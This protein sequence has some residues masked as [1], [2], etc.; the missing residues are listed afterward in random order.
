MDENLNRAVNF[1]SEMLTNTV[2]VVEKP[3][4]RTIVDIFNTSTDSNTRQMNIAIKNC[5]GAI[6]NEAQVFI[7]PDKI[8]SLDLGVL[9]GGCSIDSGIRHALVEIVAP[10]C[11]TC[12]FRL[13]SNGNFSRSIR[14][15]FSIS[16]TAP[17]FSFLPS[18][19]SSTVYLGIINLTEEHSEAQCRVYFDKHYRE[20]IK[21]IPANGCSI[22]RVEDDFKEILE[23][24]KENIPK[25]IRIAQRSEKSNLAV[26]LIEEMVDEFGNTCFT[27][28]S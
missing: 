3:R 1:N 9:I 2:W 24:E 6:C 11:F 13:V 10:K 17:F 7:E 28:V 12:R 19:P 8:V 14:G 20:I 27:S 25:Y 26:Q 15:L 5:H 4:L 23:I 16:K 22:F 21:A 18:I